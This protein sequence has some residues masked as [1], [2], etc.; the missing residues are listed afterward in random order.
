MSDTQLLLNI[1]LSLAA[2]FGVWTL[3]GIKESLKDAKTGNAETSQRLQHLE[4]MVA[5][6]YVKR[7]DFDKLTHALFEKLDKIESKIDRKADKP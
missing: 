2:F 4:V 6:S 3:T 5:G 7:E 1:A